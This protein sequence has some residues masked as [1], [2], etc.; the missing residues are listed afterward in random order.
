MISAANFHALSVKSYTDLGKWLG[1]LGPMWVLQ[2]ATSL[3]ALQVTTL[4]TLQV[5]RGAL[6][7][8][9]F[10]IEKMM[11]GVP[12]TVSLSLV[13]SMLLVAAGLF[14]YDITSAS[15]TMWGILFIFLNC[16]FTVGVTVGRR[17]F[18]K[19]KEFGVSLP[20]AIVTLNF[21]SV[22]GCLII[23]LV[24]GEAS[25]WLPALQKATPTNLFWLF[26]SGLFSGCFSLLQGR[27]QE[28]I[29]ATSDLMYQNFV[30][31]VVILLGVV[32][33]GDKFT[34]LSGFSG[35]AAL[36]GCA[37]YGHVRLASE[38]AASS[39]EAKSNAVQPVSSPPDAESGESKVPYQLI[40]GVSRIP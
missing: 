26:I 23:G 8:F 12:E 2:L 30:K 18:L 1:V 35:A 37:W 7:I 14:L 33:F 17:H 6:P 11:Y 4:S 39:A 21:V 28:D 29:S 5:L 25:Q 38:C 27:S 13:L 10:F 3:Y 22:I 40:S 36:A 15:V 34:I 19:N 31:I 20:A 32:A 24:T 16:S 9:S